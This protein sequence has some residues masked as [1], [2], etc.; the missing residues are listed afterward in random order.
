MSF[1]TEKWASDSAQPNFYPRN[2]LLR[3]VAYARPSVCPSP[4]HIGLSNID[5][6]NLSSTRSK[7]E[8]SSVDN[9]ELQRSTAAVHRSDRQ[10]LSTARF[11]R[12]G[13]LA[14]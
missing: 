2:T 11:R 14:T 9:S 13:E 10:A 6:R 12:A 5:R 8:P 3:V 4:R 1:S 7:T